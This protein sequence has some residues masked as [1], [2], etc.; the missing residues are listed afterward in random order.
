MKIEMKLRCRL[1]LVPV[2][3]VVIIFYCTV[4]FNFNFVCLQ[5]YVLELNSTGQGGELVLLIYS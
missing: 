4:M 5:A 2:L 3:L 1:Y